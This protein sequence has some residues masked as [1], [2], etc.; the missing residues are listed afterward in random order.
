MVVPG[1]GDRGPG[2]FVLSKRSTRDPMALNEHIFREYDIRGI[3]ERDLSGDVPTL[4]GRAFGSEL[5][6]SRGGAGGLRV[7]V[8][9]DNRPS[10]P[11]LAEKLIA[12]LRAARSRYSR[13]LWFSSI[14]RPPTPPTS[15]CC[16]R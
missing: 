16:A 8:G 3:V 9:H 10:S 5:R 1:P 4:L 11:G 13:L 12:G 6:E 2:P 7:V 14:R 15:G